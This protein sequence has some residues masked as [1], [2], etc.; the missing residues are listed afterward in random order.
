MAK[1]SS[2]DPAADPTNRPRVKGRVGY[3]IR[4]SMVD[5]HDCIIE[6]NEDIKLY[7]LLGQDVD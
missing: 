5:G 1:I 6:R 4:M 2:W 3:T 7:F